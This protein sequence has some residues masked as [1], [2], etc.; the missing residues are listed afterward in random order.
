MRDALLLQ[1]LGHRGHLLGFAV[2]GEGVAHV[3]LHL[4]NPVDESAA[5]RVRGKRVDDLDP[6]LERNLLSENPDRIALLDDAPPERVLRLEA[7]DEDDVVRIPHELL[8]VV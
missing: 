1:D 6:C 2:N 5:V 4:G 7:A 8:E 3:V